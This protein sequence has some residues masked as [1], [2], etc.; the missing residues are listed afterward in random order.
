MPF[1]RHDYECQWQML[2]AEIAKRD[3]HIEELVGALRDARQTIVS[4]IDNPRGISGNV[5]MD[6]QAHCDALLSKH[7]DKTND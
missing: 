5:L 1:T 6:A 2:E 7:E 3:S 4:V